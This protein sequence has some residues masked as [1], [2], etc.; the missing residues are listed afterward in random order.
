[1]MRTMRRVGLIAAI[2]ALPALAPA[3][4]PA[5]ASA[6]AQNTS[7]GA[8]L[9]RQGGGGRGEFRELLGGPTAFLGPLRAAAARL[10]LSETQRE[11]IRSILQSHRSEWQALADRERQAR[12]ALATAIAESPLDEVTIR[13][14]AS[15][16]ASV[17]ADAAVAAGRA[18]AEVAGV[19]TSDQLER[20]RQ[21]SGRTGRRLGQRGG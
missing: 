14:R 9:F 10:D 8:P 6:S 20:L 2:A 3:A 1:M 15:E 7:D 13:Q 21:I 19:L 4:A 18:W 12:A 5:P 16:L 17:Q 11:Q